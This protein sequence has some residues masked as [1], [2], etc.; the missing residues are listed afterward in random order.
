MTKTKLEFSSSL[1]E[2]ILVKIMFELLNE[3]FFPLFDF[4]FVFFK[5]MFPLH[6]PLMPGLGGVSADN[7]A[8]WL[9][10]VFWLIRMR[11]Q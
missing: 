2:L 8:R 4:C 9:I 6:I 7:S 3:I 5:F 11:F 10:A 1:P